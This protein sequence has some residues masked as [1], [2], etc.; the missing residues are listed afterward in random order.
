MLH[1]DRF[2]TVPGA[3]I[4]FH[5]EGE[6][7]ARRH[8]A[9]PW[10]PGL[11]ILGLLVTSAGSS[12]GSTSCNRQNFTK[13]WENPLVQNSFT[14]R[15]VPPTQSCCFRLSLASAKISVKP[16]HVFK[17]L[18]KN[19]HHYHYIWKYVNTVMQRILFE[20]WNGFCWKGPLKVI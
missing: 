12:V 18:H 2:L 6:D 8:K 7:Q 4:P 10:L 3:F 9:Q 1:T 19:L 15:P 20:V 16:R 14:V 17:L 5:K 11:Q 13:H